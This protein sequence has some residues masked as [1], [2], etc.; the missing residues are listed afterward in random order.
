MVSVIDLRNN[1]FVYKPEQRDYT[2]LI[3]S[4]RPSLDWS[5]SIK[6]LTFITDFLVAG[7]L[8]FA[9]INP[10]G[11]IIWQKEMNEDV[12]RQLYSAVEGP[13]GYYFCGYTY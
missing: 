10:N 5:N 1:S 12:Y 6:F 3:Y 9:K 11:A 7:G 8:I 13:D 2:L 4:S